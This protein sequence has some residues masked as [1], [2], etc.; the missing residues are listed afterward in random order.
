M[1]EAGHAHI[2]MSQ[3]INDALNVRRNSISGVITPDPEWEK[4][5]FRQSDTDSAK[6]A[7]ADVT[8]ELVSVTERAFSASWST[9]CAL[10]IAHW[11]NAELNAR[12]NGISDLPPHHG[13]IMRSAAKSCKTERS[14]S[15]IF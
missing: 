6:R 1:T 13:L 8:G 7:I 12:Q 14:R 3:R 4:K 15:N 9:G 5:D 2:M 11:K 10:T